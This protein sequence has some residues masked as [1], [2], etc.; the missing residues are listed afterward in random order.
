MTKIL[1]IIPY[2]GIRE[3]LEWRASQV[4]DPEIQIES[5]H[6]YGTPPIEWAKQ[7]DHDIIIARGITFQ[8]IRK[9]LPDRYM[10]EIAMTGF[11]VA[12][13]VAYARRQYHP[14]RIAIVAHDPFLQQM[15]KFEELSGIPIDTYDVEDERKMEQAVEHARS[16]GA[17]VFIGGLTL[18]QMCDKM[19]LNRVHIKSGPTAIEQAILTGENTARSINQERAKAR[20]MQSVLDGSKDVLLALDRQGLVTAL[21][22]QAR[23]HFQI[24]I[25]QDPIGCHVSQFYSREEEWRRCL[26]TGAEQEN[27]EE[28]HG[29]LHLVNCKPI[30]VDGKSSGVLITIQ[31]AEKITE[32]EK[33]IR[34]ELTSKGLVAKYYFSNIIGK[35]EAMRNCV[36]TAYKYS[37]VDSNVLLIGE[38]GTGKELF[39]HSIHNAR[40]RS[41]EPFVAVNC[42]ALPENLLE[43]ELFGYVEGAFSGAVKGGKTGLFEL[44]HRGTIFLDEI[45]EMPITLQAKLLRVLQE[46]EIRR[47]GDDRV[48]P[49]DV[50]VI[51]ATNIKMEEKIAA[52]QFRADLFYR[53][54]LLDIHLPPLRERIEDI[55]EMVSYFISTF[56]CN[57]SKPVPKISKEAGKMLTAYP[58]PG[59]GRELRNFCE[60]LVVLNESGVISP[61]EIEALNLPISASKQPQ[62]PQKDQQEEL[63]RQLLGEHR[64]KRDELAKMLGISRTTLWRRTHSQNSK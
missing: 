19:G 45:G 29:K 3:Q 23:L 22:N 41:R 37:Q 53:L 33:R 14:K 10:V 51:S 60:R 25:S 59:N 8:A 18:C 21:N 13:A 11:D 43:S 20:L 58:W 42:A 16:Q 32:T 61:S 48:I 55:P 39:A 9:M 30:L 52:G 49:I 46:R 17:D 1:L 50:R 7:C 15:S 40:R 12:S 31:N 38:T 6:M 47:L 28:F 63:I 62:Q 26:D 34:K 64:M 4:T 36:A 27:L 57:Y 2:A 56:A 44:A 35:S 24:S 5:T 54:N